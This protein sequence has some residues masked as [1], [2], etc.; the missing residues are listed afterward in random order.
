MKGT[1]A[2]D[3]LAEMAGI[4][5]SYVDAWGTLRQ[6][7]PTTKSALLAAMGL[8]SETAEEIEASIR[9]IEEEQWRL[10]LAPVLV[11]RQEQDSRIDIG[12][13]LPPDRVGEAIEWRFEKEQ[14]EPLAGRARFE[15]LRL[16]D[17]RA[18]DGERIERRLFTMPFPVDL[19]YHCFRIFSLPGDLGSAE[20]RVIVV[21][22]RC[23]DI[24]SRTGQEDRFWGLAVQLYGLRSRRNWGMGDFT[25]LAEAVRL[26]ASLGA[27]AIGLNPLHALFPE[28]PEYASPYSPS[29]REFLG[30]FYIDVEAVAE[31]A[32]CEE[33]QRLIGGPEFRKRVEQLR[34]G[35]LVDYSAVAAVKRPVLELLYRT[36]RERH[37]RPAESGVISARAATFRRFQEHKGEDLAQLG[38][39]QALS[40]YFGGSAWRNWPAAYRDPASPTVAAFTRERRERVEF[41][42]Y[43]QWQADLQLTAAKQAAREANMA[44]GLYH[45][46][47]LAP[48][49]SGAESWSNQAQLADGVTLGAPPDDWNQRGQN[50]GLPP[51]NPLALR[52]AGL[53]PFIA[54]VRANMMHGGALRVDHAMGLERMY[55]IPE[56]GG[57]E[58]G[59]YVRYPVDE[60][61]GILALESRRQ[62]CVV[63]GEDLGTLPVGFQERMRAAAVLSY[64]LLYFSQ[65]SGGHFVAPRHYPASA[66]VAVGTHD[67]A[68]LAGFWR[69]RDLEIRT[70]LGLYPSTA[71]KAAAF[72]KRARERMALIHALKQ[73][74]LLPPSFPEQPGELTFDLVTALYRFLARTPSRLLLLHLEDV[75]GEVEQVN[76][77]GT[78]TEHPNWRRKILLDLE[79]LQRDPRLTALAVAISEERQGRHL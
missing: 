76:I 74:G 2:L 66:A 23:Y 44:V 72:E 78:I 62:K 25:D 69:G 30:I 29:H 73:E 67:L 31:L 75:I 57:P 51:Y 70:Q 63:I 68:T 13:T 53:R 34:A 65:D 36:F 50:W 14:G 71:S 38:T 9:H 3:R 56:G 37:L 11:V 21:P 43:L 64:R 20:Q 28:N 26:G 18:I 19:G 42:Q 6:V 4:L 39:F 32:D 77:P 41:F 60:L 27:A 59:G 55:W 1:N 47:A 49:G 22:E 15:D 12:I 35:P 45:D 7:S 40:E 8:A 52:R 16:V 79:E 58:D 54:V 61:F 24:P 10:P 33:A 17:G 46:L 5:P 48:D